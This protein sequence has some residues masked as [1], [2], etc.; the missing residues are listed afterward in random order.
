MIG[1]VTADR[2]SRFELAAKSA[3][4]ALGMGHSSAR[5][6]A[7]HARTTFV[8]GSPSPRQRSR[9]RAGA[10]LASLPTFPIPI[11]RAPQWFSS[12]LAP[13]HLRRL[14]RDGHASPRQRAAGVPRPLPP[15][16]P[17]RV[18]QRHRGWGV[19]DL[20]VQ[21]C[22][23]TAGAVA[24]IHPRDAP[25]GARRHGRTT[26]VDRRASRPAGRFRVSSRVRRRLDFFSHQSSRFRHSVVS[27]GSPT[28][29]S[30]RRSPPRA[31]RRRSQTANP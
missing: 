4:I 26:R 19:P 18:L 13:A 21:R 22:E 10:R 2:L 7:T 5:V 29:P 14:L 16:Q 31:I 23:P 12:D 27:L 17:P 1:G 25:S 11:V 28:P 20:L 30:V 9:P 6:T 24:R 8:R 3:E 15:H